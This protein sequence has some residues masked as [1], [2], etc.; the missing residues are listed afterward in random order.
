MEKRILETAWVCAAAA[1]I[2]LFGAGCG[3][4]PGEPEPGE[5]AAIGAAAQALGAA[6]P[7][8][9]LILAYDA[10]H[11]NAAAE[12]FYAQAAGYNVEIATAAQWTAKSQA[13]FATYRALILP[14]YPAMTVDQVQTAA[15][16]VATW[17]PVVNGN[18]VVV[19]TDPSDHPPA[20][21]YMTAGSVLFAADEAQKTGLY[22]CLSDYYS[23]AQAGTTIGVLSAFGNFTMRGVTCHDDSHKVADHPILDGLTD[24][25]LSSWGCSVHETFDTYPPSFLPLAI[26]ENVA[27]AGSKTFADGTFGVPYIVARGTSL[28]PVNCGNGVVELGEECDDGNTFNNDGCSAQC[29]LEE[30][31]GDGDIVGDALDN[32]PGEPN[33]G[34]EDTDGDG[35]GDACDNCVTTPNPGQENSDGDALGSACD[36]CPLVTNQNQANAD[37]DAPGD[38][39]DNCPAA[40]NA[41]QA[42]I[43]GD[44]VGD[45][46]DNCLTKP[47]PGQIDVDSDG[48]GDAC[49]NCP[50]A[51]NAAQIDAD[52]DGRGDACDN[53]LGLANPT[54][55]D[56]DGDGSGDACDV[57]CV[58]VRRGSTGDVEDATVSQAAPG[59]TFG[60]DTEVQTGQLEGQRLAL[61][62]FDLGGLPPSA[63]VTSATLALFTGACC[64][65]DSVEVH[66]ATAPWSESTVTYTS[67]NGAF[68]A[69]TLAALTTC[70]QPS[71]L[72]LTALAAAW[73]AS[74]AQNHGLVLTQA[75]GAGT[76]FRSS[77]AASL[78]D[79]PALRVCYTVADCAPGTGDCDQNAQN[80]CET[81]TLASAASCGAC[82]ASCDYANAQ[83]TCVGGTC[84]LGACD[85]GAA[86]CNQNPLD[87]C[88]AVLAT[89]ETSCGSCGHACANPHGTS[90]CQGGACVPACETGYGSCDGNDGNGCETPLTST[91]DCG[92]CGTP[93]ALANSNVTCG[94]GTCS[95]TSCKG[96]FGN[97]NNNPA[98]GCEVSLTTLSNCG[99]CGVTCNLAHGGETCQTGKCQLTTCDAGFANCDLVPQTGCETNLNTSITH[100]GAC[101]VGCTNQHGTTTC[102]GGTC[103]PVCTAFFGNCDG[104]EKN[105]CET[106][107]KAISNCGACGNVCSYANGFAQCPSGTCQLTGCNTGFDNCDGAPANG[108]ETALNTLQNC[109]TCG[110]PCALGPHATTMSCST[111]QCQVETCEA[112]F[113]DCDN[114]PANGCEANLQT[115]AQSCGACGV[116]C[117]NAHGTTACSAGG[118]VP[119][120]ADGFTDCDGNPSNGCETNTLAACGQCVAAGFSC[121]EIRAK[122]ATAP[123][124]VYMIDDDGEGP[125]QPHTAYCDMT[126]DGGGWTAVF[127]GKNGRANAFDRFDTAVH[128]GVYADA[129]RK[130]LRRKTP[131]SGGGEMAV[132]CG[133]AMVKFAV[134]PIVEAYFS[135]GV[136]QPSWSPLTPTVIAGTVPNPPN[137]LWAGG[138]FGEGFV[139]AANQNSALVFG[140]SYANSTGYD[141]CNGTLDATS[142][143][144]VFYREP[145]PAACPANTA[146]CDADPTNGCETNTTYSGAGSCAASGR[147]CRAILAANPGA[148]SGVYR[149]DPDGLGPAAP[150]AALC[151][152]TTDG[153]GW[154]AFYVGRNGSTNAFDHFESPYYEGGSRSATAK[155]LVR[156]PLWA[157]FAGAELAVSCGAAAVKFPWTIG[158]E[159]LF[160]RG[161]QSNWE[162]LAGG[163]VIAGTV[164]AIPNMMFTGNTAQ[165][166]FVF[167]KDGSATAAFASGSSLASW[168]R[169]NGVAD[170]T[171]PVRLYYREPAVAACAAGTADC[172][173]DALDG[174]ET[175]V[176]LSG[177]ACTPLGRT[178]REVHAAYPAAPSGSYFLDPDGAGPA[179]PIPAYCDMTT[180]GGGWTAMFTGKNG[181]TNVFDRF[182]SAAYTGSFRNPNDRYLQR[183]VPYASVAGVDLAVSCGAAMVKFPM[184]LPADKLFSRGTQSSWTPLP[185]ATVLAGTVTDV[186]NYLFTGSA[187]N[188]PS[189]IFAKDQ[190][191]TKTFASN[192]TNTS[193]N[194]CNSVADTTSVV[195]VFFREPPPLTCPAGTSDCDGDPTN[196][197]EIDDLYMAGACKGEA[198]CL[199]ILRKHPGAPSGTYLVDADGGG[200]AASLPVRCD[201]TT[202][203][204]GYTMVRIDDTALAADALAYAALCKQRG[205][206][207]VTPRTKAHA[208]SIYAWNQGA[209]PNVISVYPKLTGAATLKSWTGI[210][211]GVACPFWITDLSTGKNCSATEPNGSNFPAFGLVR[212][213][214]GC[215]TEGTWGDAVNAVTIQDFVICSTNDKG[216]SAPPAPSGFADCDGNA[217]NGCEASLATV[218]HCGSCQNAC[219]APN[220]QPACVA[221]A[222]VVT[223]CNAGAADCDAVAANGC[224]T[225]LLTSVA[226]CGACGNTCTTATGTPTCTAG[227]C[228]MACG[229]S[230]CAGPAHAAPLCDGTTC[231]FACD[232]GFADCDGQAAN[233]CEASLGS[234][235]HCGACGVTCTVA[236]GAG[237]CNAGACSIGACNAGFG[238]CDGNAANGCEQDLLSDEANCGACGVICATDCTGGAC[239]GPGCVNPA[240]CAGDT[241]PVITSTPVTTGTEEVT[242]YYAATAKDADGDFLTWSLLQAPAGMTIQPDT[243]LVTWTPGPMSAGTVPVAIRVQDTGGATFTQAFG[244][245]I[246]AVLGAPQI[247][248]VPVAQGSAGAT[249]LYAAVAVDSDS[250][251]LTWTVAGPPAMTVSPA[252]VVTWPVPAGTAGNFP[253]TL[254][255]SDGQSTATQ[256]F[257]VGVA[258][259]GDTTAPTVAITA[260]AS[261]AS[262]TEAADITGTVSDAALAGYDVRLCRHWT[263]PADAC[264]TIHHGT[265]PVQNG[266]LARLDP[267]GL[268]NGT[269][270]LEIEATDA[271][272]NKGIAHQPVTIEGYVK[273]GVVRLEFTDMV[274]QT[275]TADITISRVYDS[276]DLRKT[277]LGHGFRY[278]WHV[279]H[280]E[281]PEELHDGWT[282]QICGGFVPKICLGAAYDHPVRF[283]LPD[284]RA[285]SFLVEVEGDGGLSS[286][287]PARPVTTELTSYGATLKTLDASFNPYSDSSFDLYEI[288]GTVYE[289]LDF[290][291]WEPAYYEL[292]TERGEVLT[293][294]T[295]TFD[296]VKMKDPSGVVIELT[297]GNIVV[298][299]SP[300]V[301][302]QKGADGLVKKLIDTTS[303]REVSYVHN[304]A[305][306]LTSVLTVDA[307]TQTFTYGA[308]HRLATYQ[309]TGRGPEA[310]TYDSRGRIAKQVGPDGALTLY[311]YD[312]DG[313]TLTK[314]DAAGHSATVHYDS[315]GRTTLITDP[316]GHTTS[317]TYAGSSKNIATRTDPLGNVYAYEYDNH[318]RRTKITDPLGASV[319]VTFDT[320][321][322]R[323]VKAIDP[324]GRVYEE[325]HDAQGR[326]TA[327]IQPDGQV[328]KSFSYP[329]ADSTVVTDALGH[330]ATF[331]FDDKARLTSHTDASGHTWTSTYDAAAHTRQTTH[332]DGTTT[333][334]ELD[335]LDRTTKLTFSNG[336][337]FGYKWGPGGAIDEATRPDGAVH[338]WEKTSDGKISK[339]TVA[340][341]EIQR[342]AYDSSGRV[343]LE[344][345]VGTFQA[346][347]YDAAGRVTLVTLPGGSIAYTYDAAGRVIGAQ[348]SNGRSIT[349]EHDAAGRMTAVEDSAGRRREMAYDATGRL[350]SYVDELDRTMSLDW[351]ANGRVHEVTYPDGRSIHWTYYP[352]D[353]PVGEDEPV[354]TTD[355]IEGVHWEYSYTPEGLVS[356]V[357]DANGNLTSYQYDAEGRAVEVQDGLARTTSMTWGPYGVTSLALPDGS[358]QTWAYAPGGESVTWTRAD[359]STVETETNGNT[360][361]VT[362]PSGAV[363][364]KHTDP[365]S[366]ETTEMG[367]PAGGV[368]ESLNGDGRVDAFTTVDGAGIEMTYT[369]EG[370]IATAVATAPNGT[371]YS[372]SYTYDSGGR[373]ASMVDPSG[374]TTTYTHDALGRVTEV[375]YA[376]G[377][378]IAFTYGLLQRPIQVAHRVGATV[379]ATYTYTYGPQGDLTS[380]TTPEGTFT[381]GYDALN[382]LTQI[383]KTLPGGALET[384][385]RTYDAV[386]NLLTQTDPSG[387]TTYTY[388]ANDRLLGSIGPGGA[389]VLT[390]NGRGALTSIAGP[391]GTTTYAYDD[392]DRLVSVTTPAGETVEY[393][394]DVSGRLLARE[395]AAGERRCLPMPERPDGLDDCALQYGPGGTDA[396]AYSY[397]PLGL[398][399]V[400]TGSGTF[401]PFLT[402]RGSITGLTDGAAGVAA[403]RAYDADGRITQATGSWFEHGYLG[404]RQD[405][406]TGLVFLRHRWYAPA[407]GRFLTPDAAPATTDDTR[408]LHRYLYAAGDPT[409]K[410]DR[411]GQ[412]FTLAGISA[413]LSV[414]STLNNVEKAI[415]F[416]VGEKVKKKLFRSIATYVTSAVS[417]LVLQLFLGAAIPGI[418]NNSEYKFQQIISYLVCGDFDF[419][420]F[421]FAGGTFEFEVKED[422]CGNREGRAGTKKSAYFDCRDDLRAKKGVTGIDIVFN[423]VLPIELKLSGATARDDGQ[424]ARWCRFANKQHVYAVLYVYLE[425]PADSLHEKKAGVCWH[426]W[427]DSGCGQGAIASTIG[428]IYVAVGLEQ[429]SS[430]KRVFVPD[431]AGL[432]K[433]AADAVTGK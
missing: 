163:T 394:Y 252:G 155:Y 429:S 12:A 245:T 230:P 403:T 46:C 93:C 177:G 246:A 189:F 94:S 88:E 154:T 51:A 24:V 371:Q 169:C 268:S 412:M 39:C 361:T 204:G 241:P 416:C 132:Q 358:G 128:A 350:V 341:S 295:Q 69:G 81:D 321:S 48:R 313:R 83:G 259:P 335:G 180:D 291:P 379:V 432:C 283:Q 203:G 91:T 223:G 14:D 182:D 42:D 296:V 413:T 106:S 276:L 406:A 300:A 421:R 141:R 68:E 194:R 289:D 58:T 214:T 22:V 255:V 84:A 3:E 19:G 264:Q 7:N 282:S 201:M 352:S 123:T 387:T 251:V 262:I 193:Y 310:Y 5:Q 287:H 139:F 156:A 67:L 183:K 205:M 146:D 25:T 70:A 79:R 217:V 77:E 315:L 65:A 147:S 151:D 360:S 47:N 116:A 226:S 342:Y 167:T 228:G 424:T 188:V 178:C 297:D 136:Q 195:R 338:K 425:F 114:L 367:A 92:A 187:T 149:I 254:S 186:P 80:G 393:K 408:T 351:D 414:Q 133:A 349:Y 28:A 272:G 322:N 209:A 29:Q 374:Q 122:D 202:D 108:C 227:V 82:G 127:V 399:G 225:D 311:S 62:R 308:G 86:D 364:T 208:A 265:A 267:T 288:S 97:C 273:P 381:Y 90:E 253:V 298:D 115:G 137:S 33:P 316:L 218:A 324:V 431:P 279:G 383:T 55:K 1:A 17:G 185:G 118:C 171:S 333:L 309:T 250:P 257:S 153:G 285:Y 366:G 111:L 249:Y 391:G 385:T 332:P 420:E 372:T 242:W 176:A 212:T 433:A 247:V 331:N 145:A 402:D 85:S 239:A 284:G 234:A 248:S 405:A 404:E 138:T 144:R 168:N 384:T 110:T 130:Y 216:A 407:I 78:S 206:E 162:N 327:F 105:G 87:G 317:F 120:C 347:E 72:D 75:G 135:N 140:S 26:A 409:N 419:S 112:G 330:T 318:A 422:G 179:G 54:Q 9:V 348:A 164:A 400:H 109:G 15:N 238:D 126:T 74:P 337:E 134:T 319:Q 129:E 213:G 418:P 430:G 269:Y 229:G 34:Q 396:V 357:V 258:A 41:A 292:T 356:E 150:I 368:M 210:C 107:L 73:A 52:S 325:T 38:A 18:I 222:C 59:Q 60:A 20:G 32:C 99:G 369:P 386:G 392:L 119:V 271:A 76:A 410:A 326:V 314:T 336:D 124:G 375:S 27:G 237:A 398:A 49:D 98:D 101:G 152:M 415:K 417:D 426:C 13:D 192:Q 8:T 235:E 57:T 211:K 37:G 31:D 277:E 423:K 63:Q 6:Q 165:D 328:V 380:E 11:G 148:A 286:I 184:T 66:K 232:A 312:D 50:A 334:A 390:Y 61:L 353:Q 388:D 36:N 172:N 102:E 23:T 290:T 35:V 389:T 207:I 45:T 373:L 198:S 196:G 346:Y 215:G 427:K 89:S 71:T 266:L 345:G 104:N 274:V 263:A 397:G 363:Y 10:P 306:E 320:K 359:G 378:S 299:G 236:N 158:M 260:P 64:T 362:L 181:S 200:P 161:V 166:S 157:S 329:D 411:K 370:E 278:D 305:G 53:C 40:A 233:G 301:T 270:D 224:E 142:T 173:G 221:G 4:R 243:G 30:N 344:Q 2:G 281:R 103:T 340:G 95:L 256:V 174:C 280:L 160:A 113:A 302:V 170:T 43:D 261:G 275:T 219:S 56:A 143:L 21:A 125:R 220:G 293:F 199:E 240:G 355:D 428:S 382:R 231:T 307:Q 131:W 395:D 294:R 44:G 343:V 121:R 197:C 401:R 354:A 159:S 191:F 304:A 96:G 339:I 323:M 100:C 175:N 377:T 365:L 190:L 303:G 117:T 16:N 376:N 244:L